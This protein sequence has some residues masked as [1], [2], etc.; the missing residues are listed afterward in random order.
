MECILI[1]GLWSE[2][3]S[4]LVRSSSPEP[5]YLVLYSRNY[6]L[7]NPLGLCAIFDERHTEF[8]LMTDKQNSIPEQLQER[9]SGIISFQ[10][11][12]H[13]WDSYVQTLSEDEDHL[14]TG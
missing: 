7:A 12:S 4:L 10:Q 8:D 9:G 5:L 14:H 3:N 11:E 6:V 2:T 13:K 1:Y